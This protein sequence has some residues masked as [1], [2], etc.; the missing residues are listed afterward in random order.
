MFSR[1]GLCHHSSNMDAFT[2]FSGC[3]K[4]QN[5]FSSNTMR[6]AVAQEVEQAVY[7]S[8]QWMDSPATPVYM[9]KYL[10]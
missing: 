10:G 6:A 4:I 8:E 2:L 3:E 7:Q 9:L 1:F 5:R